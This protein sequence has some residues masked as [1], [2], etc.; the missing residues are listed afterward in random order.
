[1]Q[2]FKI[3]FD[4]QNNWMNDDERVKMMSLVHGWGYILRAV[5]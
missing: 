3:F 4:Y 2:F 5:I 1:M